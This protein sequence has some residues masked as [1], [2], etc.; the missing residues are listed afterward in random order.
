MTLDI[1]I[2]LIIFSFI[3]GIF[4]NLFLSLNYRFIYSFNKFSQI[5]SSFLF[6]LINVIIYF[7]CLQKINNGILHI[8]S[9]II[10]ILSYFLLEKIKNHFK[11]K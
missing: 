4:F 6:V 2:S 5:I 10:I 7:I 1:Q 3:Y 8:Y 9:I 11:N